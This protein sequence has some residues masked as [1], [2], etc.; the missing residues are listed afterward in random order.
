[1]SLGA[2][3]WGASLWADRHIQACSTAQDVAYRLACCLE[4]T[5]E[6]LPESA[7]DPAPDS[8]P[9]HIDETSAITP[10]V[11]ET[12]ASRPARVKEGSPA[13]QAIRTPWRAGGLL[14]AADGGCQACGSDL[15]GGCHSDA[16][17]GL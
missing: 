5:A 9:V 17:P 4:E 6:P 14:A 3:G 12:L 2:H 1:V 8:V 15:C 11:F 7:A 10:E 16:D 13:I